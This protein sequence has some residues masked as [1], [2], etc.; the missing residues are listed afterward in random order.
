MLYIPGSNT[1]NFQV[2]S[3][4]ANN[5]IIQVLC[6]IEYRTFNLN[7]ELQFS[8]LF[9]FTKT[10]PLYQD[11]FEEVKVPTSASVMTIESHQPDGTKVSLTKRPTSRSSGKQSS[12]HF[13]TSSASQVFDLSP[14]QIKA[15]TEFKDM[16]RRN[17][18]ET[19]TR[20][21]NSDDTTVLY[22]LRSMDADH[23]VSPIKISF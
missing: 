1:Q 19:F 13:D 8:D 12:V 7:I 11:A 16:C 14:G 22:V 10:I 18:L 5:A 23:Y 20:A 2:V 6:Q 21:E 15:M 9:L 3:I 17:G 4:C